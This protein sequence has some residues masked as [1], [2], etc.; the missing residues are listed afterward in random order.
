MFSSIKSAFKI[1][2]SK[3]KSISFGERIF[4]AGKVLA[5]GVVGITGFSLNE[6]IEKGLTSIGVPFASFIAECLSGLFAGIMSAIVIMLF[7]KLKKYFK[8]PSVA[9]QALQLHSRSLCINSAQRQISSLKMDMQMF[10]A[11]NFIGQVFSSIKEDYQHI[12]EENIKSENAL[13]QLKHE[14]EGQSVRL[15]QLHDLGLMNNDDEF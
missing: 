13:S 4:E 9:V 8:T 2:F 15:S 12:Q 10:G 11:Y 6:L 14:L 1:I 5:A 3:D 7:D